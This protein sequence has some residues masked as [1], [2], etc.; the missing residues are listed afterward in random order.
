MMAPASK[1]KMRPTRPTWAVGGSFL[2]LT[3]QLFWNIPWNGGMVKPVTL[4]I[5]EGTVLNCRYPAAC[6]GASGIGGFLTSA[7][8]ACIARMLYA[9]GLDE[10]VNASWYGGGSGSGGFNTGGP[11]IMYGGRNQ[12]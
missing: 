4:K 11:G 2:W 1:T 7:A 5:P 6:G 12:H 8:S 9:A 3:S 10:D